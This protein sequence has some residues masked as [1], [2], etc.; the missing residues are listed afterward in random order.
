MVAEAERGG[1]VA[2]AVYHLRQS[3]FDRQG[4]AL[5]DQRAR[6]ILHGRGR[7]SVVAQGK[8][9]SPANIAE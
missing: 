6:S 4:M 2:A 7:D 8:Y 3:E 9:H 5:A 1:G